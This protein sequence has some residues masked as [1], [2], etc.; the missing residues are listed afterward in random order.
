MSDPPTLEVTE[1][2]WDEVPAAHA[3]LFVVVEGS[4]L[5]TGNAALEQAAEVR[6]LVEALRP[7]GVGAGDVQ[8]LGVAAHVTSGLLGKSSSGRYTLA[9]RC[10]DV[11]RLPACLDAITA[12]KACSLTHTEWDHGPAADA[13]RAGWLREAIDRARAKAEAMA[14]A[15]GA[16]L[17]GV[18][19]VTERTLGD[20]R[21][22]DVQ[23]HLHALAAPGSMAR[24]R[25]MAMAA[26]DFT[27]LA[28][29][30]RMGVEVRVVYAL[31]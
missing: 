5:F 19:S 7:A 23:T 20:P 15:L 22:A 9:I 17:A 14:A 31:G 10:R 1:R 29:S 27:D 30:A 21:Y 3:R 26:P 13:R 11:A 2:V 12:Q 25:T 4:R 16:P 28:P 8:L 6:A 18:R 24:G